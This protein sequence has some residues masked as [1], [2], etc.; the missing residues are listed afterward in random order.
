[1]C[2]EQLGKMVAQLQLRH[3]AKLRMSALR[4]QRPTAPRSKGGIGTCEA[5]ACNQLSRPHPCRQ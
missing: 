2:A 5:T 3:D 4:R 1:M